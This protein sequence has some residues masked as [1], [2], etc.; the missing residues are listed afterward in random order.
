MDLD[1]DRRWVL[2]LLLYG[3]LCNS[4]LLSPKATANFCSHKP[5]PS[6]LLKSAKQH[7]I[8]NQHFDEHTVNLHTWPVDEQESRT[9]VCHHAPGFICFS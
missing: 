6:R 2:Y 7:A 1:T 4:T 5:T 3:V 8:C 9:A